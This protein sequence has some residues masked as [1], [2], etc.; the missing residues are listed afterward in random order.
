M[1]STS[2]TS[3]HEGAIL[4][5]CSARVRVMQFHQGADLSGGGWRPTSRLS[6]LTL[7]G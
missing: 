1:K 3:T 6:P 2:Y 5:E 7:A 4:F